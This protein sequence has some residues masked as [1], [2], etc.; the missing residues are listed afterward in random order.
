MIPIWHLALL[1]GGWQAAELSPRE[2]KAY[3]L[4]SNDYTI[5]CYVIED[6]L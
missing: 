1:W 4:F 5:S 6:Q 3:E 2:G